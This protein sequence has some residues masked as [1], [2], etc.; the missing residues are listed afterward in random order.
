[1][2]K[3]EILNKKNGFFF[4]DFCVWFC[5]FHVV[6]VVVVVNAVTGRASECVDKTHYESRCDWL[7][8]IQQSIPALKLLTVGA[9]TMS[10][11]KAFH[12]FAV[13]L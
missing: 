7:L 4:H 10:L 8:L 5:V 2:Y 6:V 11:G 13:L 1:M 12:K 3:I 9:W